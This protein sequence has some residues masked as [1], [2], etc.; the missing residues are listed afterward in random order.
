VLT[1][2]YSDFQSL[3][4]EGKVKEVSIADD[5]LFGVVDLSGPNQLVPEADRR[6]MS[7]SELKNHAFTA[8]RVPDSNLVADLRAA[9]GQTLRHECQIT[10]VCPGPPV[11]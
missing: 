9:V 8:V 2:A 10:R 3:L 5:Q 1:L 11:L 4:Q 7:E 6:S